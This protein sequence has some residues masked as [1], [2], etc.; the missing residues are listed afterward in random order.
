MVKVSRHP[1]TVVLPVL[2]IVMLFVS[3]VF[4][5]LRSEVTRHALP[6]VGGGVVVGGGGGGVVVVGGGGVVVGGGVDPS[7]ATARPVVGEIMPAHSPRLVSP[8]TICG[9]AAIVFGG[10]SCI[11]M[12]CPFV[13]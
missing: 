13:N 10:K 9:M 7:G 12:I 11:R 2:V 8:E 6:V 5:A 1:L 4:Q 3:P